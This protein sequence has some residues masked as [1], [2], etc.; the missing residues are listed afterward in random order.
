M[1]CFVP[2]SSFPFFFP[3][4]HFP[5]FFSLSLSVCTV[6]NGRQYVCSRFIT[7]FVLTL[8]CLRQRHSRVVQR[9]HQATIHA[10]PPH[11]LPRNSYVRI[12]VTTFFRIVLSISRLLTEP[13]RAAVALL[14]RVIPSPSRRSPL[15]D[16]PPQDLSEF[17][18]LDWVNEKGAVAEIL[19]LRRDNPQGENTVVQNRPRNA[20]DAHVAFPGGRTEEGD[21]DG[22]YTG[23]FSFLSCTKWI[24]V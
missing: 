2:P 17:F 11:C 1:S 16:S 12:M 23:L 24:Y 8:L 18:K 6:Y 9:P 22:L 3:L 5:S 10:S 13:R 21:E 20:E 4:P 15:P 19:F 7:Y 14:I